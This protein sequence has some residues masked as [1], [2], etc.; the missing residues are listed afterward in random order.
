MVCRFAD[1]QGEEGPG[2]SWMLFRYALSYGLDWCT[3]A[4]PSALCQHLPTLT[5]AMAGRS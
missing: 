2:V 3:P 1:G 5:V 4:E